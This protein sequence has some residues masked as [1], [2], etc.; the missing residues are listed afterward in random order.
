MHQFCQWHSILQVLS[1]SLIMLQTDLHNPG[2]RNSLEACVNAEGIKNKMTKEE[3]V[4][5]NRGIND[6]QERSG[7]VRYRKILQDLPRE[8]LE[9]LYDGLKPQMEMR[10]GRQVS[11]RIRFRSKR[12]RRRLEIEALVSRM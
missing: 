8:Y 9:S 10:A 5:N 11:P 1:F 7:C 6:N 4:K 12:I 3:F 2:L